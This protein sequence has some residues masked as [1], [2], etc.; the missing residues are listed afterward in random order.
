MAD[1]KTFCHDGKLSASAISMN[2]PRPVYPAAFAV[3]PQAAHWRLCGCTVRMLLVE[4]DDFAR[5]PET[6]LLDYARSI[7]SL[8]VH[9]GIG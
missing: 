3:P 8:A 2:L 4:Y 6:E 7:G 1:V 9:D 5:S